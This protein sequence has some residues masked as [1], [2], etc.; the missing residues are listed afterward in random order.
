VYFHPV[1]RAYDLHL[2]D[3]M[4]DWLGEAR[5]PIDPRKHLRMTD[6]LV[7]AEMAAAADNPSSRGHDPALRIE[8]RQHFRCV[9][10]L[11]PKDVS[12]EEGNPDAPALLRT[13]LAERF[14][15]YDVRVDSVRRGKANSEVVVL[16]D[17]GT[18]ESGLAYSDVL[19]HIPSPWF[20]YVFARQ[21]L[22]PDVQ[23]YLDEHKID[24]LRQSS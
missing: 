16:R 1:R 3:F 17:N 8:K 15:P 10:A 19:Q 22:V 9:C 2:K 4:I 7:L 11:E 12:P 21:E 13:A 20:T 6:N 24:I 18:P 14:G 5:Y 23:K